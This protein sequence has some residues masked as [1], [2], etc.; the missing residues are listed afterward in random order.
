LSISP[1]RGQL[2]FSRL[3]FL[4]QQL[5]GFWAGNS[6]EIQSI[7]E[8]CQEAESSFLIETIKKWETTDFS[9]VRISE[10]GLLKE[11]LQ[12]IQSLGKSDAENLLSPIAQE[13]FKK[14]SYPAVS[15]N[16]NDEIASFRESLRTYA[17]SMVFKT[18]VI[19]KTNAIE[20][21]S[22]MTIIERE[23]LVKR[24]EMLNRHGFESILSR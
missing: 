17:E 22:K 16:L 5:T 4:K 8:I 20:A 18:D 1:S 24:I 12:L 11:Q 10:I 13:N 6:T 9:G 7:S 23:L 21:F 3:E 15:T 14:E 2:S 19:S